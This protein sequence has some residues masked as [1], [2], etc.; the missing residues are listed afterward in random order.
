MK[1]GMQI[2]SVREIHQAAETKAVRSV[3][4]QGFLPTMKDSSSSSSILT[5]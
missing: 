4:K 5:S 2:K 3:M 1:N